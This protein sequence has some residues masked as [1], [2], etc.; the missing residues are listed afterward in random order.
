MLPLHRLNRIATLAI[1][2]LMA[3]AIVA[4]S[5]TAQKT[6]A[7]LLPRDGTI[8]VAELRGESLTFFDLA[9]GTSRQLALPGPA[10][11]LATRGVRIYATLGRGNALAE[12][13]PAGPSITHIARLQ[14]EPHGLAATADSL[15]VTLDAARELLTIDP[16]TYTV[17]K[18]EPTGDTPHAVAAGP[19]GVFVT[20]SRDN[21]LRKLPS[22]QTAATGQTPE[23]V[24][25][26]GEFVVTADNV[27]GVLTV[28]RAETLAPYRTIAVGAGPVRVVALGPESVAVAIGAKSRVEIVNVRTGKVEKQVPV[29]AR[30]D[31][32]CLNADRSFAAVVSNESDAVQV[33]RVSDWRLAGT[34]R[35]GSGP[36]ACLWLPVH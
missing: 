12:V 4:F 31:G 24:A 5:R 6:A 27:G 3:L 11:E 16:A 32:I 7:P 20:D 14:G 15:L 9:D 19:L 26:V 36:G 2:P 35:T 1:L 33:F 8:V 10:H 34:L 28:L 13:D 18:R 23:S 17:T 29:L 21:R 30:P 22:R 25:L